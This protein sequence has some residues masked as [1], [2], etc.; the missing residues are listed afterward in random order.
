MSF[1]TDMKY[2]RPLVVGAG[3]KKIPTDKIAGMRKTKDGHTEIWLKPILCAT[4]LQEL[5]DELARVKSW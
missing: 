1:L 3:I 4:P 5:E 2:I